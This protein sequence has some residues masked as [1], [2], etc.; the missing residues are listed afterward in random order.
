M[1][2][3]RLND[4]VIVDEF[5][6][7][8]CEDVC[9]LPY[10]YNY[11]YQ[12]IHWVQVKKPLWKVQEER[13]MKEEKVKLSEQKVELKEAPADV[14]YGKYKDLELKYNKLK[15]DLLEMTSMYLELKRSYNG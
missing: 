8:Q 1:S 9:K 4:L 12:C 11:Q 13:K 10:C 2:F 3:K 14:S 15:Q 7:K 5:C 6:D